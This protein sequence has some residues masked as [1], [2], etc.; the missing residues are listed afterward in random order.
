MRPTAYQTTATQLVRR[1][2]VARRATARPVRTTRIC[3]EARLTSV[4]VRPHS[5]STQTRPTAS[6]VTRTVERALVQ[7]R[8]TV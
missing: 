5:T 7:M 3:R 2:L 8:T 4:Y 1:A 6:R